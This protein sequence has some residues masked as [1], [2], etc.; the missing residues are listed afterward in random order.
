MFRL[1]IDKIQRKIFF[2][3]LKMGYRRATAQQLAEEKRI[4]NILEGSLMDGILVSSLME[5]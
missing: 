5:L 4:I 1:L 3:R 2:I